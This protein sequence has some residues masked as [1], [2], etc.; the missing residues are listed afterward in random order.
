MPTPLPPYLWQSRH[1]STGLPSDNQNI[2]PHARPSTYLPVII[3]TALHMLFKVPPDMWQFKHPSISQLL[4]LWQ[5]KHPST[6]SSQFH[7]KYDTPTD[8]LQ[9]HLTCGNQSVTCDNE[10]IRPQAYHS[11]TLLVEINPFDIQNKGKSQFY[12]LN[13]HP[14]L[15]S[16]RSVI[17]KMIER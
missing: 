10:N 6:V 11:A 12:H 5:L 4:C 8:P 7:L 15:V 9:C 16:T 2:H 3:K 13:M 1:T 14:F 17:M